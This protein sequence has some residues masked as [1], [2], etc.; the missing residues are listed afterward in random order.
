VTIDDD[1]ADKLKDC[2]RR[3][4]LSLKEA[5]NALLRRGLTAP[6][7]RRAAARRFRVDVF[8]SPFRSGVDPLRLNQL[9]DDLEAENGWSPRSRGAAPN[10]TAFA[11]YSAIRG[12]M[13]SRSISPRDNRS[14][15][16]LSE[17]IGWRASSPPRTGVHHTTFRVLEPL[18]LRR[19]PSAAIVRRR[20][21]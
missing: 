13:P 9:S 6:E 17:R 5:V 15:I 20:S 14:F 18:H 12:H 8:D 3:K 2:A 4:R 16:C 19:R 1:V 10:A 21:A 7:A 11:S